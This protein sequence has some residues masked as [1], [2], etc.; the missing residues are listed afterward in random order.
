MPEGGQGHTFV[1]QRSDKSDSTLY[2]LKR[3]KNL[4][5][6]DYFERE[7]SVCATLNHANVLKVLDHGRTPKGKPFLVTEYC[8]G[9]SLD[10]GLRFQK[11]GDGLR[12]FAQI[13]AGIAYAHAHEP[14][15]YHLDLKPANVLLKGQNPVIGDFGICFVE[16]EHLELTSEGPRGSIYY[17]AP[18]LRG[19]KISPNPLLGRADVYSLG[20]VLYYVFTGDVYDGHED[21]YFTQA[22]RR[23]ANRFPL[24]PQFAFIDEII[25]DTVRREP[26]ERLA[27]GGQLGRRV[28]DAMDRVEAGGRVLDLRIRQRCL[29][30]AQGTYRPAHEIVPSAVYAQGPKFPDSEMRDKG[31]DHTSIGVSIYQS[32]LNVAKHLG[33]GVPGIAKPLALVC[34]YC[35]NVQYFRLD[36]T[37]QAPKDNWQP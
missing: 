29:Y 28:Q 1:V 34:D 3:L 12:F 32:L 33:W 27:D 5:R 6:E 13:A 19:P 25:R 17:C 16:A 35:G 4:R 14:A 18:E 26:L 31:N 23:L 21:D 15:V 11:P 37:S 7:I 2:V 30:C 9:G 8:A 10:G 22:S 24:E 20:K 36:L